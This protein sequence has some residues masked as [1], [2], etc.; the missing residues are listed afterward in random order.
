MFYLMLFTFISFSIFISSI[1][2][3]VY[4]YR[5]FC[6]V[7]YCTFSE[8]IWEVIYVCGVYICVF[9]FVWGWMCVCVSQG[10]TLDVICILRQGLSTEYR[11]HQFGDQLDR[12][13][14][15]S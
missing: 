4:T 15:G 2:Q 9:T 13:F 5:L 11:D 3:Y 8:H 12:S 7:L 14:L 6:T 1:V 10:L